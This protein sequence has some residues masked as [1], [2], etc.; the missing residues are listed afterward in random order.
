MHAD[1]INVLSDNYYVESAVWDLDLSWFISDD[2]GKI[3]FNGEN[4]KTVLHPIVK[5]FLKNA[6]KQLYDVI[7][8]YEPDMIVSVSDCVYINP[9][10]AIK[11][12]DPSIFA[13][14]GILAIDALPIN[15]KIINHFE[16]I[17]YILTTTNAAYKAITEEVNVD[18]EYLPYGP[19]HKRFF[20]YKH[21]RTEGDFR[22]M[23][24]S[25]NSQ[26]SNIV[27]FMLALRDLP[28]NINGYLH[29]N[30]SSPGDYDLELLIERYSL[31][32]KLSFPV[33]FVSI[34]DG[35]DF[36]SLNEQYNKS[37]VIL[38]L[39][40]R[41]ST[42]LT[43]LEGMAAGCIPLV[44]PVGALR[45]VVDMMPETIREILVLNSVKYI[46]DYEKE[47]FVVSVKDV[48]YKI[49]LLNELR[50]N[51]DFYNQLM[52]DAQTVS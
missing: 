18:C 45:E 14:L 17:D 20:T 38:D 23:N 27:S 7:K 28:E 51:K 52:I 10:C 50:K 36:S 46:G 5:P 44:T 22:I 19:N 21:D 43:V 41:S 8:A 12:L 3:K 32:G 33:N 40:V 6:V 13:W 31:G 49:M 48:V 42:A 9:I 2:D 30:M 37:N 35:I 25:T 1:V 4:K 29:T 39:S 11:M 34:N 15:E 16:N 24:C 47:Y 26:S